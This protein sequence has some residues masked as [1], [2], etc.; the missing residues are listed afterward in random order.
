MSR[1]V[2]LDTQCRDDL[3]STQEGKGGCTV[4]KA[5]KSRG[6]YFISKGDSFTPPLG[7][8]QACYIDFDSPQRSFHLHLCNDSH[9][10][11]NPSPQ[12][13]MR[14]I[15]HAMPGADVMPSGGIK[16]REWS[17]K[18]W[19]R[20]FWR[21][22][23]KRHSCGMILFEYYF[24]TQCLSFNKLTVA[25]PSVFPSIPQDFRRTKCTI[26]VPIIVKNNFQE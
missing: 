14:E 4:V 11:Q 9:R 1:E 20:M 15:I 13:A 24:E 12:G 18:L 3:E 10:W 8:G 19:P 6:A 17:R 7:G 21:E 22:G 26:F 23:N 5:K 2:D 25:L 16:M